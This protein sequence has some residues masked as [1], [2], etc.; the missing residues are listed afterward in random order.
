[1]RNCTPTGL[2]GSWPL[3]FTLV[4]QPDAHDELNAEGPPSG[5]PS[6]P[7]VRGDPKLWEQ[8]SLVAGGLSASA[9]NLEPS[10]LADALDAFAL[11]VQEL[12]ASIRSG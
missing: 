4:T 10:E 5:T 8:F 12:A 3:G 1:M 2:Q 11:A 9:P 7:D 6:F